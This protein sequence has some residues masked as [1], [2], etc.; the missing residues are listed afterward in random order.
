VIFVAAPELVRAIWR[1]KA[2]R[3]GAGQPV[4]KGWGS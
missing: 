4:S 1:I 2:A 3:G